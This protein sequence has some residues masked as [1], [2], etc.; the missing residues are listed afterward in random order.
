MIESTT[1]E[2][3]SDKASYFVESEPKIEGSGE[4]LE[5]LEKTALSPRKNQMKPFDWK[6]GENAIHL[7]P[8][9]SMLRVQE[10]LT[11]DNTQQTPFMYFTPNTVHDSI[12]VSP[13]MKN[14]VIIKNE[15]K[16]IAG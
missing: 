16:H 10:L 12:Y 4:L 13:E 2:D 1:E 11:I 6:V 15:K 7:S 9:N 14:E 8:L 3:N 5:N